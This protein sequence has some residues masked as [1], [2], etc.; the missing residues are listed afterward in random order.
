MTNEIQADIETTPNGYG[1]GRNW[2]LVLKKEGKTIDSK[3]LGQDAKVSSRI[4]GLDNAMEY[5]ADRYRALVEDKQAVSFSD[6]SEMI[7]EDII[8]V[9]TGAEYDRELGCLAGGMEL[10]D[11]NLRELAEKPSWSMAVE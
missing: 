1:F 10:T 9:M 4:L 3:Y 8:A 7:A 5:Y 6:V 2:S 11:E